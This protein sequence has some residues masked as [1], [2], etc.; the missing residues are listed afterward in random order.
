MP[1]RVPVH[2]ENLPRPRRLAASLRGSCSAVHRAF[3]VD[4]V[5]RSSARESSTRTRCPQFLD[6]GS[7][8]ANILPNDTDRSGTESFTFF[9]HFQVDKKKSYFFFFAFTVAAPHVG[10]EREIRLPR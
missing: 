6:R 7:A 8:N 9:T 3:F 4:E 5:V 1:R 10:V 2:E